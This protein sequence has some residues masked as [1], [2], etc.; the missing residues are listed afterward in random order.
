MALI[1]MKRM[2]DFFKREWFL[3]VVLLTIS[4]IIL[5]FQML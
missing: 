2:S 1:Y 3:L 5:L 4:V